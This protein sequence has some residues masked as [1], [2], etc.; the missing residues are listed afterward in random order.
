MYTT[1]LIAGN[2]LFEIISLLILVNVIFSWVRP[3][4]SN[5][6]V[7]FIY[8]VTEPLLEPFRKI[9]IG[10]SFD[11]SPLMA[12]LV[13]QYIIAPLYQYVLGLIF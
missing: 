7:K 12:I 10:R 13:L 11:F 5:P 6:L 3:N 1:L 4:P 9:N 8:S 2:R